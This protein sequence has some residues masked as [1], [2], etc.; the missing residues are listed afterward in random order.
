MIIIKKAISILLVLCTLLSVIPYSALALSWDGDSAGGST[1]AVNG[2]S[3]GYVIRSTSDSACVVGYRFSVVNSSGNMKVTKVIDVFR[4]TS[5]G[6]NAY[7]TSAKFSTKYNKKQINANKNKSL[8]TTY[9]QTNCYKES[10]MEFI[11]SLPNPSGVETWQS[12]ET[13]I[14]KVL[15]KLGVGSVSNMNNGDKVIVEPLFDVCLAGEYQALTVSEIAYCGRS[16]LGGTSTGG[17]SNGTSSTWGFIANY[18]NRIWP[19]KLYT[20]DGQGLWSSATEIVSSKKETF[21]GLL[22]KG[23]G[24]GIAYNQTEDSTLKDITYTIKFDG[25][26]ATG[27]S[28][29]SMT[30]TCGI[31]KNLTLN[32]FTKTGYKFAGWNTKA[33]GTGINYSNGQYVKDLT[34]T[35]GAVV[36]LYAKWEYNLSLNV[37]E[38]YVYSGDKGNKTTLFGTT[39]GNVFDDY[40]YK[41]DYPTIGD[42]VWYNVYFPSEE[43]NI[44]VRQYVRYAGG[45]WNTRDVTLSSSNSSS[46]WFPIQFTGN[47]KKITADQ[48]YFEIQAKTDWIDDS[49]N[50]LKSGTVKTFYIPI[51]PVV[52]R[53]EV[54]AYNYEGNV[55]AYDGSSGS[56]GKLY[57]GQR[58]KIAYKYTADNTWPATEYLRGS[59]YHY[60]GSKW[61]TVYT[62]NDGYDAAKNKIG[63]SKS[64]PITLNS[65]IGTYAVPVTSQNKLR[66][67]LE[68]WWAS[69]K[70]HTFEEIWYDLPV[71][72]SDIALTSITLIDYTTN[73]ILDPNNLRAGQGVLVTYTYKNNT[74]VKVYVE[75]F[76]NDRTQI[77]GVYVIP[78]KSSITVEGYR[79]TVPNKRNIN[80]WGGVYLEGL[81]IYN[82]D[83][84]SNG[85]NN[86]LTLSCKVNHPLTLE[87]IPQNADY[88]E[89]TEVITSFWLKNSFSDD[90]TPTEEVSVKFCVYKGSTLIYTYTKTKVI[91]PGNQ[92]NLLY[93]KWKVP[94]G[95]NSADVKITG[96]IIDDGV[97]YNKEI[98]NYSTT[99]YTRVQTPDTQFEKKGPA[100]F[101]IP[102]NTSIYGTACEWWEWTYSNGEFVKKEYYTGLAYYTVK[103]EPKNTQ[104]ASKNGSTWYMNSGYGITISLNN[105]TNTS[106]SGF[107]TAPVDS[108]TLPQYGYA[109][110]PEYGYSK[111]TG[112]ITT[113]T[114]S[115]DK[116]IFPVNGSYGNV[117]FTP[118]WYPDG[119]YIVRVQ[120]SD[121]WTPSGM[122]KKEYKSNTI[123]IKDSAYD[124]WY[125]GR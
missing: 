2:S 114:L 78:A 70:T 11:T 29:S 36:T 15:S 107:F 50:V 102:A 55:V 44:K 84:E 77:N 65:S 95:L 39:T 110:F 69:D 108:Y 81:G 111:E 56:S 18:T 25:N 28:T 73:E 94:T 61:S 9:N 82:T 52:Y 79:F 118:L 89:N 121:M 85:N 8:T 83:Y 26:G 24:A 101:S 27:G 46:Q 57:S 33:N 122:M 87:P 6:N 16:V 116:W 97:S 62:L 71:V 34:T 86:A 104:T 125:V 90:Y 45:N 92:Y 100:G 13:N 35:D 53:T 12:Y 67:N 3:T 74:D 119:D 48:Q 30:M 10:A 64:S 68:T 117:H 19:N 22:T 7:S 98:A 14:N 88:R 41:T 54:C 113:L 66:F 91:V 4:N 63:I 32:G 76:K 105:G 99:P 1:D 51:K 37:K 75:G 60:S 43:D 20:P 80:I 40:V 103:I 47:Y 120:L 124:D 106:K 42:T 123:I 109:Y 23:Y 93:F 112:K 38:C 17:T 59:M 96:E 21:N 72:K 5:N 49:G 58:V 31:G 115:G